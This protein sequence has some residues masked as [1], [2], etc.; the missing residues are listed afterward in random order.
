MCIYYKN[1]NNPYTGVIHAQAM[2]STC[3]HTA[4]LHGDMARLSARTSAPL[5]QFIS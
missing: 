5:W 4:R 1:M 2:V 3:H